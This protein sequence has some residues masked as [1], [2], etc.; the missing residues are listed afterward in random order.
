MQNSGLICALNWKILENFDQP[1]VLPGQ[2]TR[3]GQPTMTFFQFEALDESLPF[4]T[5]LPNRFSARPVQPV[6]PV[7]FS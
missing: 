7:W 2:T 4:S 3:P 6:E 1:V 5:C